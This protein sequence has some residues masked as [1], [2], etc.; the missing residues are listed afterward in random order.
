MDPGPDLQ[1]WGPWGIQNVGAPISNNKFR[2]GLFFF[3]LIIII[4]KTFRGFREAHVS[5]KSVDYI[6][7]L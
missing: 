3:A 2:L 5:V 7:V 1:L 4:K 6:S